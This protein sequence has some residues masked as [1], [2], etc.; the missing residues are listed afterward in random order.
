[1]NKLIEEVSLYTDGGCRGNPGLGAIGIVICEAAGTVLHEHAECIGY[2][3]NNQAE[4]KALIKGLNLCAEYT[5]GRVCCYCD[6]QIVV[7]Q[8]TGAYRLK[9][10]A[11]RVLFDE[12]KRG[13][14]CFQ[15]VVFQHV[16]REHH[17]IARADRLL[18]E[19]FDGR[20]RV[21]AQQ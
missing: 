3:T 21:R 20:S 10:E 13:A 11:L 14:Q 15:E 19:A 4:Y 1:V 5:R 8:L 16:P 17:F 12:V 2:T 7:K 9:H 6:S 18:N